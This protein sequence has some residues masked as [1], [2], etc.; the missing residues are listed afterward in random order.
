[1]DL[2]EKTDS[3]SCRH[4]WEIARSKSILSL[5]EDVQFST[6]ADIG[7]GD[8]FFAQKLSS[9]TGKQVY[10]CDVNYDEKQLGDK[11]GV[12]AV[13]DIREIPPRSIDVIFLLDVLEHVED[14]SSFLQGV[15]SRLSP[16]GIMIITVPAFQFLFG[17][18][19]IFLKHFRR[20]RKKRLETVLLDNHFAVVECFYFFG[21]LFLVKS[22]QK[23]LS[24]VGIQKK[25]KN[26]VGCWKY[27]RQHVLTRALTFLLN[28]DFSVNK[29][30]HS[31][32]KRTLPG[33]SL[34]AIVKKPA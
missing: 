32:F 15:S 28:L 3:G 6:L 4:P 13:S 20:Y 5:L 18:H 23:C 25:Y 10:A 14:E 19:D 33:F 29:L 12:I 11:G 22:I 17:E 21:S 24:Q 30:F 31:T 9:L 26:S 1:M 2:K 7:A 27:P 34:C 16:E 8:L